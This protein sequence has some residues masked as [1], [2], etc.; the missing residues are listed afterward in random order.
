[1]ACYEVRFYKSFYMQP[2]YR[3]YRWPLGPYK[4]SQKPVGVEKLRDNGAERER[5]PTADSEREL[6]LSER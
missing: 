6:G 2:L 4:T 1:M 5:V 3:D